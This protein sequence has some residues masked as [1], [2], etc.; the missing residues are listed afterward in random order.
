MFNSWMIAKRTEKDGEWWILMMNRETNNKLYTAGQK[1]Y[2]Q[3]RHTD[4][5]CDSKAGSQPPGPHTE[6]L[7]GDPTEG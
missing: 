5:L 2:V 4:R 7:L 1:T 6:P 3:G